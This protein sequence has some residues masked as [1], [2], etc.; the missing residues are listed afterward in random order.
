MNALLGSLVQHITA[1]MGSPRR[2]CSTELI[3]GIQVQLMHAGAVGGSA[4][5]V[6]SVV[7]G[8]GLNLCPVRRGGLAAVFWVQFSVAVSLP[9]HQLSRPVAS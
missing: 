3:H 7:L 9:V 1:Q 6:C 5:F 8:C 2:L 4:G